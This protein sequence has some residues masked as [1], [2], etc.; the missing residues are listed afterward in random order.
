MSNPQPPTLLTHDWSMGYPMTLRSVRLARLHTRR[1]LTM[2]QWAGDID[3]AVLV[4]SEL[5]A[6]AVRHGRLPG[7]EVWLRI[8][9][10]EAGALTVD[11]SDPVRVF[12]K[13]R[14]ESEGEGGRGLLVVSQLAAELDWFLRADVGK[15][16]RA[17]FVPRSVVQ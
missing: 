6:N 8:M 17:R 5:V 3:D 11:V 9:E 2:W 16:V 14:E 13:V 4:T 7:H 10:L 1:R 12:P 15:T